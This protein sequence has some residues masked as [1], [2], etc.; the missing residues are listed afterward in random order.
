VTLRTMAGRRATSWWLIVGIL[1]ALTGAA[2]V[3][4][5]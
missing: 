3:L 1:P 4:D 2:T 5:A